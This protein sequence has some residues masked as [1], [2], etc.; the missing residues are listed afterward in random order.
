ML[1]L[2]FVA[3]YCTCMCSVGVCVKE[4][5]GKKGIRERGRRRGG[6]RSGRK[7][8]GEKKKQTHRGCLDNRREG[9]RGEKRRGGGGEREKD[10]IK[11]SYRGWFDCTYTFVAFYNTHTCM[12]M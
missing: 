6:K 1:V 12:Y 4:R 9:E 8:E 2:C 3:A 10:K 7:R 5:E 11:Q